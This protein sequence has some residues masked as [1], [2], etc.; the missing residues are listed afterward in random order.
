M[1]TSASIICAAVFA[2]SA[3]NAQAGGGT[4]LTIRN[5]LGGGRFCMDASMDSGV[6]D[7]DPVYV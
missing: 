1:N 3:A 5:E 4:N 7:G 6:H 2:L